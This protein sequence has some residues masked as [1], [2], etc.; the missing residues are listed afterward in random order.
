[1]LGVNIA[2]PDFELNATPD[3]KFS[4][5]E[6]K[7][8]N[9]I[10]AFYPADWSPVCGD[11]MSLYNEMHRYFNNSTSWVFPDGKWC[12]AAFKKGNCILPYLQIL[13]PKGRS[14]KYGV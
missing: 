14:K 2:A 1:M 4:L 10:I 9:V 12:H 13:N 6:L 3:Q 8:K 7:G 11:Q 5:G